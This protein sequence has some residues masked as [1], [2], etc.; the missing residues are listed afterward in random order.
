MEDMPD[1]Y[2][3]CYDF[4]E[5]T[6]D[7]YD[8]YYDFVHGAWSP[9]PLIVREE[10]SPAP[11]PCT[12]PTAPTTPTPLSPERPSWEARRP[13]EIYEDFPPVPAASPGNT[14]P[15]P[16]RNSRL[17]PSRFQAQARAEHPVQG[18]V[19][20]ARDLG[21][22]KT[23]RRYDVYQKG[24]TPSPRPD[25]PDPTEEYEGTGIRR[26]DDYCKGGTPPPS[27]GVCSPN[28]SYSYQS[29]A[30]GHDGFHDFYD[31]YDPRES[32]C[33]ESSVGEGEEKVRE[34][35]TVEVSML[36]ECW[37]SEPKDDVRDER[38][39]PV[40]ELFAVEPYGEQDGAFRPHGRAWPNKL[41]EAAK[42]ATSGADTTERRAN[43]LTLVDT[44]LAVA[45]GLQ[46]ELVDTAL[47][48]TGGL[49]EATDK[50]E[51]IICWPPT[52]G[53]ARKYEMLTRV[54]ESVVR[55]TPEDDEQGE[56]AV[57]AVRRMHEISW[58]MMMDQSMIATMTDP[59]GE[60]P[61]NE[62]LEKD[63]SSPGRPDA[64]NVFHESYGNMPEGP[65][66][67]AMIA[68]LSRPCESSSDMS[69]GDVRAEQVQ[70]VARADHNDVLPGVARNC[71]LPV[72]DPKVQ[73][74]TH[75]DHDYMLPG[76]DP[77]G[78]RDN[79][80]CGGDDETSS[81]DSKGSM[82]YPWR[83]KKVALKPWL[84]DEMYIAR[85]P[86]DADDEDDSSPGSGDTAPS[87]DGGTT[88]TMMWMGTG[89]ACRE[90]R[91][92]GKTGT[93]FPGWMS[94]SSGECCVECIGHKAPGQM[95]ADRIYGIQRM[96][97]HSMGA[98]GSAVT[99]PANGGHGGW[100]YETMTQGIPAGLVLECLGV[101]AFRNS[102]ISQ[103][104]CMT[105]EC[106]ITKE[107]RES[108]NQRLECAT[109][110]CADLANHHIT[111]TYSQGM[112]T[113]GMPDLMVW[114]QNIPMGQR[115]PGRQRIAHTR[116]PVCGHD[117]RCAEWASGTWALD[118]HRHM[119]L[120]RM[121]LD[122]DI[123]KETWKILIGVEA[124]VAEAPTPDR[125]P[126]PRG[127]VWKTTCAYTMMLATVV[128]A[129]VTTYWVYLLV[130]SSLANYRDIIQHQFMK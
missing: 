76:T 90:D 111:A 28:E 88:W 46:E 1:N 69:S 98:Q 110:E 16:R 105:Q 45:G 126:R 35:P 55:L 117:T 78:K 58:E 118:N 40:I 94:M 64:W 104:K 60:T 89:G 41:A 9:P 63:E 54:L 47:A 22:D 48:V 102:I 128:C 121:G 74:V 3:G 61:R 50:S 127:W 91:Q 36:E 24:G 129:C 30:N 71:V 33:P 34:L 21:C 101:T 52:L 68:D 5:D 49:Q 7:N 108:A 8:G 38:D 13:L 62:V 114:T 120:V 70:V 122:I 27:S 106:A 123:D 80:A 103:S 67:P 97:S 113:W 66:T 92:W 53:G 15:S 56:D 72:T 26:Y 17:V 42:L 100:A 37:H 39:E 43:M 119:E 82:P 93:H 18:A 116:N 95:P 77:S 12:P 14:P 20:E 107:S 124:A 57:E 19:E 44:A 59:G 125:R 31:Q 65:L 32:S 73:G 86:Y 6:L 83:T 51:E 85:P 99:G 10:S 96:L 84:S 112:L 2:D 130:K 25:M 81:N 11:L 4:M 29:N 75:G 115:N 87:P 109:L 23:W 79:E